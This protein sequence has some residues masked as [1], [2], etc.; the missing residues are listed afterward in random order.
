MSDWSKATTQISRI[1][2]QRYPGQT[3]L[4]VGA[5]Y[6]VILDRSRVVH[7]GGLTLPRAGWQSLAAS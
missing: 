6:Q 4:H 3:E 2:V 7:E 5:G 1:E